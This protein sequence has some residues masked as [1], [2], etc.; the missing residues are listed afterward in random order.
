MYV[1]TFVLRGNFIS[2]GGINCTCGFQ[3]GPGGPDL[4]LL[5]GGAGSGLRGQRS[6]GLPLLLSSTTKNTIN[7]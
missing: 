3:G 6:G 7:L 2:S 5:G 4:F 1:Y